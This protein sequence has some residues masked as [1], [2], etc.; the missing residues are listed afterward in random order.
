MSL[1]RCNV[2]KLHNVDG[3]DDN[4]MICHYLAAED[5]KA[6]NRCRETSSKRNVL[7]VITA[8]SGSLPAQEQFGSG[9]S[10]SNTRTG[11]MLKALD[12]QLDSHVYRTHREPLMRRTA[13]AKQRMFETSYSPRK[14]TNTRPQWIARA[15]SSQ[16]SSLLL[17]LQQRASPARQADMGFDP[18]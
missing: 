15:F 16:S 6:E 7:P 4:N 11:D 17:L 1:P 2:V 12:C 3:D 10:H 5:F 14:R 9:G 18:E 8:S 13:A